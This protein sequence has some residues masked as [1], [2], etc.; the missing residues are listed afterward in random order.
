MSSI[1]LPK[2]ALLKLVFVH[3]PSDTDIMIDCLDAYE[4]AFPN[5]CRIIKRF[6]QGFL[7]QEVEKVRSTIIGTLPNPK[8][9]S[10]DSWIVFM[11]HLRLR[12]GASS[13][14]SIRALLASSTRLQR[15]PELLSAVYNDFN[16]LSALVR[17]RDIE[18]MFREL[19]INI[20]E[21]SSTR[22]ASNWIHVDSAIAI[23]D[24]IAD[25]LHYGTFIDIV[26][27]IERVGNCR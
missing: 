15:N 14:E 5:V 24:Y 23:L 13:A 26:V 4:E 17:E 7:L 6:F 11:N 16:E 19:T 18:K 21:A 22:H 20:I 2:Q 12:A 9:C 8:L 27:V 10:N 1:H 3:M 25:F